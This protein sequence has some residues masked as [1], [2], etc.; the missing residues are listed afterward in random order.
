MAIRPITGTVSLSRAL[1]CNPA[2]LSK[3]LPTSSSCG[4]KPMVMGVPLR[5]LVLLMIRKT[6][7]RG[8][9]PPNT[10]PLA[11][12]LR[13]LLRFSRWL[14]GGRVAAVD[15]ETPRLLGRDGRKRGGNRLHERLAGAGSGFPKER[16]ELRKSLLDRREVRGVGWQEH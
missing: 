4:E 16:F 12:L 11:S 8:K 3:P 1:L 2:L 6:D 7:S 9:Q 5:A 10:N 14:S 15:E 13:G